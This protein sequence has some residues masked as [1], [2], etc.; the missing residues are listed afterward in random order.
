MR[1]NK[2]LVLSFAVASAF[3]MSACGFGKKDDSVDQVVVIETP[4]PVPTIAATATP[5]PVP[6]TTSY[7]SA[8]K[9]ISITLP[10]GTWSNKMDEGDTISFESAE[11]DRILILHQSGEDMS[12]V[13]LPD[14]R[15]NAVVLTATADAKEGQDFEIKDYKAEQRGNANVYTYTVKY[16]NNKSVY[17]AVENYVIANEEEVYTLAGSVKKDAALADVQKSFKTFK[18][19]DSKS[20][21]KDATTES[22]AKKDDKNTTG[23]S[24]Q[25][26]D[27]YTDDGTAFQA[28]QNPDG[29]WSDADGNVF[30]V[31]DDGYAYDEN[32]NGYVVGDVYG[33]GNGSSNQGTSYD[34]SYDDS[35][36]YGYDY[37]YSYDRYYGSQGSNNYAGTSELFTSDGVAFG[38][39]QDGNG[40]WI[41]GDGYTFTFGD[42]G[43]AYDQYGNPYYY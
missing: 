1:K 36:D 32:G 34:Y 41:D 35:Y 29:S 27:L 25:K 18:I 6:Q 15:D 8:N 16:L 26:M 10:N 2:F 40:N 3:I 21:L 20:G 13:V 31:S 22:S 7:T 5:T 17:T 24:K 33:D 39:Y 30:N 12:T 23:S 14:T 28:T 37:D 4:T 9:N 38:I 43:V 11:G 19:N 42:D